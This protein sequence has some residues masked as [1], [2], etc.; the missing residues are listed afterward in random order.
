MSPNNDLFPSNLLRCHFF[1]VVLTDFL[2][3]DISPHYVHL[4]IFLIC[5]ITNLNKSTQNIGVCTVIHI[6]SLGQ[7]LEC[8]EYLRNPLNLSPSFTSNITTILTFN[9]TFCFACV[10]YL[11]TWNHP[12][13]I[14]F[15]FLSFLRH[16]CCCRR[17]CCFF[18][19]I[20]VYCSI[21]PFYH[22][23]SFVFVVFSYNN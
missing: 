14:L 6:P 22:W 12:V 9:S 23:Q 11:F 17:L 5:S 10:W 16:L 4:D 7:I 19:V 15:Y 1:S 2:A 20:V 18:I 13:P 8:W 21:Y 3:K